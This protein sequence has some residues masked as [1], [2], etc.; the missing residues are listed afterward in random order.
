MIPRWQTVSGSQY[1]HSPA[2]VAALPDARLLQSITLTLLEAGQ[3]AVDPPM[4][5]VQ[6]AIVGGVN[7]YAGGVTYVDAEYDERLGEVLRQL[8]GDASKGGLNFG[9]ETA[10]DIREMISQAFF[11]NKINLPEAR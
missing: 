10:Q 1:A 4:I 6:E 3:K 8:G 9:V 11:L 7:V 5:A 2:T